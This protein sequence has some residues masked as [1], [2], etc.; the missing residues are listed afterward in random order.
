MIAHLVLRVADIEVSRR[1]YSM[2]G[3]EFVTE[4]HGAGPT[5]YACEIGSTVLELYPQGRHPKSFVRLGIEVESASESAAAL[6]AAGWG[7]CAQ[8]EEMSRRVTVTD[9]DGNEID[10]VE[11]E[12]VG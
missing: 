12:R 4:K 2:L 8:F 7:D 9:P 5:H 1:F 10:L 3:L 6:R 11:R